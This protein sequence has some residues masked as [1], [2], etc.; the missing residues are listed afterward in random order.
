MDPEYLKINP[1]GTVPSLVASPSS[2]PIVDSRPLLEFLDQSRLS[3]NG[4]N[5]TPVNAQ[6]KAAANALIELVHSKELETGLLIF[7]C[8]NND[9]LDRKKASPLFSY[10]A[11]RNAHLDK[12]R[13]GDPT[14]TFYTAKFKENGT[15]HHLYTDDASSAD[16]DAFFKDTVA[17]YHKFAAGLNELDRQ[18][19]LPYAVG[20]NVTLADVHIAPWLSH[21]LYALDTTDPSDFSKL[22]ARIQQTVPDFTVGPRIREWWGNFSKRESF[23]KVF[24]TLH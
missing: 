3:A 11:V 23:R 14:N 16:R 9:E 5:L 6:D 19:R 18:I 10:L 24:E 8:L 12:Y 20:A 13:S 21:A 4:S 7:G 17:G 2:K 1:N 15:L 22:E